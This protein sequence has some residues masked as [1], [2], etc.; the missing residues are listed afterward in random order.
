[1][2]AVN[3]DQKSLDVLYGIFRAKMLEVYRENYKPDPFGD[4]M[5]VEFNAWQRYLRDSLSLEVVDAEPGDK[6]GFVWHKDKSFKV[7]IKNPSNGA[8]FSHEFILVPSD[9]AEKALV[10]GGLPEEI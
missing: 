7:R 9:L 3:M 1:M 4:S 6:P 10:M 8:S 2:P 5:V